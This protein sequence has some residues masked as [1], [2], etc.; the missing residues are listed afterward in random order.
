MEIKKNN[1]SLNVENGMY[2]MK[3]T[4]SIQ[5]ATSKVDKL[6]GLRASTR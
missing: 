1:F 5:L 6:G 4:M 3:F 2:E